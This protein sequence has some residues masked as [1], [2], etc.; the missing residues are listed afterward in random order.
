MKNDGYKVV[1][2]S[3]RTLFSEY[4]GGIFLGFSA[5]FPSSL[6]NEFLY[7]NLFCPSIEVE[8]SGAAK[9]ASRSLRLIESK[10]LEDGFRENEVI[11][12]HPYYLDRVIGSETE[13]LGLSEQDPL[14]WGPATSTFTNIF[15]GEAYMAKKFHEI[16][17]ALSVKK[18]DPHIMVGGPGSWQLSSK[19]VREQKGIN[20]II[21][22]E[23]E[24][25]VSDVFRDIIRGNGASD[26]IEGEPTNVNQ[27]PTSVGP[28]LNGIVE[29][30]RGCGRGCSFCPLAKVER[31]D[32]PI[33]QII[34]D[35]KT[36]CKANRHTPILHAEDVLKYKS[37]QGVNEEAVLNLFKEIKSLPKVNN[38]D[39]SHFSISSVVGS[40]ELIE[41]ISN[42]LN[43]GKN[44]SFL[45]GQV[46]VETASPRLI[47]KHMKG[48]LGKNDPEDWP[49]MVIKAFKVL[50]K[51]KWVPAATVLM[52]LPDERKEDVLK[53]IELI[54]KLKNIRSLIVPLSYVG[55]ENGS[56]FDLSEAPP[57][58]KELFKKCWK[59]NFKWMESL[60]RD[61]SQMYLNGI[62]S[63]PTKF[64]LKFAKHYYRKRLERILK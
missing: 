26:V 45:G 40:P 23:A 64:V 37:H 49:E 9:F 20:S 53:N 36:N 17:E 61:Y 18:N 21:V 1:L 47:R 55:T 28:T 59:H 5:C 52:G 31:R 58:Y 2:S 62:K 15:G 6:I 30:S 16:L 56:S 38:V 12:A 13:I 60:Y 24:E 22:G 25:I 3:D 8:E 32:I 27:I 42:L 19:E 33:Q 10:L 29:I 51:N 35:I 54:D 41:K 4:H 43:L 50:S 34:N 57:Y 46:G 14:G 63:L 7:F 44:Q 39:I 11:V 48:K